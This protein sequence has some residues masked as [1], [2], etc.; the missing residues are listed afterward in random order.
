MIAFRS[1]LFC[2]F[3]LSSSIKI[4]FLKRLSKQRR[5]L[6]NIGDK[7]I[8]SSEFP[9]NSTT[10]NNHISSPALHTLKIPL[11]YYKF[12]LEEEEK[13]VIEH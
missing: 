8:P 5:Y 6:S 2:L 13:D 9:T 12:L 10:R 1:T 4:C 11:Q 7:V 3:S